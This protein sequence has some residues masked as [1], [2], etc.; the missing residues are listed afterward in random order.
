MPIGLSARRR[1]MNESFDQ[2]AGTIPN[3]AA[4]ASANS[5]ETATLKP[6][7]ALADAQRQRDDYLE[8]LQRS[9]AEFANFQ[10]RT[11]AQTEADR[12]YAVGSLARDL[13]DGLDNLERATEALRASASAGIA[14]GLTMVHKQLLATLA[15]H[16]VEPIEALGRP[17]DPNQHEALVQQPDADHPEG[18]VV[19]ELAKGFRIQDRVLRPT[20]VAVSIKPAG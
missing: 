7:D 17:F 5:Q 14:E 20:K 12:V 1:L 9:R 6:T 10:K 18:T 15:K 4:D 16:G 3:P 19:N 13:L 2:G 8:Q 11:K